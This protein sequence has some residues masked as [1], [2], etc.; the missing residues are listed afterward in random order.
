[1]SATA[2]QAGM[3]AAIGAFMDAE[4][5]QLTLGAVAGRG[6]MYEPDLKE[7]VRKPAQDTLRAMLEAT[8]PSYKSSVSEHAHI[9]NIQ[10]IS[11]KMSSRHADI[12]RGGKFRIGLA[13]KALNLYL[14]YRW[15]LGQIGSPP[16]CPFD[17][18]ILM[19]I[20]G[21]RGHSWI[22][23]DLM[24]DYTRLVGAARAVA[25]QQGLAEWELSV[26]NTL[27]T[28]GIKKELQA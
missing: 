7:K 22:A 19:K 13:Q 16:H 5:F 6:K 17:A 27:G 20:P 24:E 26:Y 2:A 15:C 8:W 4:L 23:I 11:E 21:W 12:L 1:M 10:S 28:R 14:K 3:D 9:D 18:G 25:G